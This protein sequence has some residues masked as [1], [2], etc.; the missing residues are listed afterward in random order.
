MTFCLCLILCS[1][2]YL[3]SAYSF[4]SPTACKPVLF[5]FTSFHA[6]TPTPSSSISYFSTLASNF[7]CRFQKIPPNLPSTRCSQWPTWKIMMTMMKLSILACAELLET[8]SLVYSWKWRIIRKGLARPSRIK[9]WGSIDPS[10][11]A[12]SDDYYCS[13]TGMT[14]QA[15]SCFVFLMFARFFC[16]IFTACR[17]SSF[18]NA[19]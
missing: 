10:I 14:S 6:N 16:S 8:Y 18:A 9:K 12:S 5:T 7:T 3:Q 2:H 1:V 11:P 13:S 15:S 19:V 4:I 17:K